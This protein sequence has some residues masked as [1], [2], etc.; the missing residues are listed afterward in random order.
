[1]LPV[2]SDEQKRE[3]N[4][5]LSKQAYHSFSE[6]H[7]WFSIFSRPASNHFTRVQRCTCCFVLL[8]I[9][10]LFNILYYDQMNESKSST[11]DSSF[12]IGPYSITSQQI[13]IGVLVEFLS[14][15]P[16]LFLVQLFRRSKQRSS[17]EN[18]FSLLQKTL[19]G[20]KRGKQSM[21]KKSKSSLKFPWWCLYLS[22]I[23]SFLFMGISIF[24]I[25]ILGIQFG[26]V[27]TQKWVISL[28]IGFCSSI[29]FT[30]PLKVKL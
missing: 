4:H 25:I 11:V 22:Y 6:G 10:M 21:I 5:V 19:I 17:K 23:L 15:I 20:L 26:D 9:T 3:F 29:F 30:Q 7:L 14:F 16:N 2:A 28:I 27:K 12:S 1:L 24:F 18:Q 13:G 8:F